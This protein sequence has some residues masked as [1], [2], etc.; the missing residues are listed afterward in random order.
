MVTLDKLV[1]LGRCGRIAP[2]IDIVVCWS[3]M[4]AS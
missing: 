2:L 1:V 3:S 4:D